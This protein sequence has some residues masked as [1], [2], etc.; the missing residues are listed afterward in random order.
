MQDFFLA[1]QISLDRGT[2]PDSTG[3]GNGQN[4]ALVGGSPGGVAGR[5]EEPDQSRDPKA[6]AD[7]L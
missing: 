1:R 5:Y 6:A 3:R 2:L 4:P 7:Q